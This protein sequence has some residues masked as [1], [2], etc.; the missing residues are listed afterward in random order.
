MFF[1]FSVISRPHSAAKCASLSVNDPPVVEKSVSSCRTE[2]F[3]GISEKTTKPHV[4]DCVRLIPFLDR[5]AGEIDGQ[6]TDLDPDY[7]LHGVLLGSRGCYN[8]FSH[9]MS[10]GGGPDQAAANDKFFLD[11]IPLCNPRYLH[12]PEEVNGNKSLTEREL[13]RDRLELQ[14]IH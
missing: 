12:D 6:Q 4:F 11:R 14:Y 9:N 10:C 13:R 5:Y 2:R 8:E 7:P 1:R 3:G